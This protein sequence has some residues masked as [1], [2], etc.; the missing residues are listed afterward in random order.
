M[1]DLTGWVVEKKTPRKEKRHR[2]VCCHG[3]KDYNDVY[4]ICIGFQVPAKPNFYFLNVAKC[5][6]DHHCIWFGGS[7]PQITT[8]GFDAH[9]PLG[10]I[11]G[12]LWLIT[13]WVLR[14]E[15]YYW[16]LQVTKTVSSC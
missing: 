5:I 7:D 13:A 12:Q 9:F 3:L 1:D 10:P 16:K 6:F 8:N 15:V 4:C 2:D 14:R 11:R